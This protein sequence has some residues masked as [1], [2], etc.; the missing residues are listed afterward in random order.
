MKQDEIKDKYNK[1]LSLIIDELDEGNM[2]HAILEVKLQELF[3]S[4]LLS[5]QKPSVSDEEIEKMASKY[6]LYKDEIRPFISGAI[7]FR[8]NY[9]SLPPDAEKWISVDEK[10][11]KDCHCLVYLF[12]PNTEDNWNET[13][14]FM[15]GYF[16]QTIGKQ[17]YITHW[18]PLPKPPI[19]KQGGK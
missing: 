12:N 18:M 14:Y 19:N 6:N 16:Y 5:K 4:Y 11:K 13:A 8:N 15:D 10:P 7:A 17:E 1:E 9:Q 2:P 3:K